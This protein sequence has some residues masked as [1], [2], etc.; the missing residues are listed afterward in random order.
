MGS[1][2]GSGRRPDYTTVSLSLRLV[3]HTHP[4]P[5]CNSLT[6]VVYT[7]PR[8]AHRARPERRAHCLARGLVAGAVSL[9]YA[10]V[11]VVVF[12]S[13]LTGRS[14]LIWCSNALTPVSN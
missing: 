6:A 5:G 1:L 4:L 3:G 8:T 10:A 14:R 13:L 11:E 12:R 2:P 7:N 9:T